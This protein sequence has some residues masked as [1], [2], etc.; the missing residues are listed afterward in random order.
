MPPTITENTEVVLA[1]DAYA[2][3]E[4]E[5]VEIFTCYVKI[6]DEVIGICKDGGGGIYT[7]V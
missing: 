3:D 5:F 4:D 2:W 7:R 1:P 6:G